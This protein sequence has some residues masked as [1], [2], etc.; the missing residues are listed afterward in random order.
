MSAIVSLFTSIYI[1]KWKDFFHQKELK[2]PP[3]F[4]GRAV[5]YPSVEILRD[6]LAWR[7]VDC[8]INN[9]YNTCFWELVKSGKS[10]SEAQNFLKGTQTGDKE[11][12]LKQFG[13]DYHKLP[14]MFRQG[15]SIFWDKEDITMMQEK[16]KPGGNSLKRVIVEHCNIIE[17]SFWA[18]HPTILYR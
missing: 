14:A 4:D 8:H 18:A 17:P 10:K 3:Y 5:C 12:L 1:T 7:Q 16:E 11:K 2:Y 6:Y 15:S 13:I 9:Q